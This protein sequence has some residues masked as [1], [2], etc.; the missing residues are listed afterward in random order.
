MFT[1]FIYIYIFVYLLMTISYDT[2]VISIYIYPLCN[3]FR[4]LNIIPT[5]LTRLL[6]GNIHPRLILSRLE[7]V[8][9]LIVSQGVS[10]DKNRFASSLYDKLIIYCTIDFANLYP[11]YILLAG[12]PVVFYANLVC[13]PFIIQLKPY[14]KPPNGF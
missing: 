3:Y 7:M 11:S 4:K 12:W 5:H 9:Q 8:E 1:W 6:T 2:C 13:R 14:A 10:S